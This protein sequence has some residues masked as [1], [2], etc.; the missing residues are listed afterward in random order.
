MV[1]QGGFTDWVEVLCQ[2]K[3][4]AAKV[5]EVQSALATQGFYTG[6]ID[7]QLG[8]QTKQALMEYQRANGL[9]VGNLNVETLKSLG[10]NH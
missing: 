9:P 3:V 8:A 4:T 7:N 1:R 5:A 10:V 6:S 2:A